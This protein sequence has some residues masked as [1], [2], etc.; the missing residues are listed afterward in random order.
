MWTRSSYH[1]TDLLFGGWV[2]EVIQDQSIRDFENII[3]GDLV[4][5][6]EIWVENNKNYSWSTGFVGKTHHTP[7]RPTK[8]SRPGDSS[9]AWLSIGLESPQTKSARPF[10]MRTPWT[11]DPWT[12]CTSVGEIVPLLQ[13]HETDAEC[14]FAFPGIP[15]RRISSRSCKDIGCHSHFHMDILS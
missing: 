7:W 10:A 15:T 6:I 4:V 2:Q 12:D 3:L 13:P 9:R 8:P 1:F 5:L 14:R 11:A